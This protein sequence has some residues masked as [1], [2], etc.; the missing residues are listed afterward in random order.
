VAEG[1]NLRIRVYVGKEVR[2]DEQI[3][4]PADEMDRI[5]P[6]LAEKHATALADTPHMVEIEFLDEP[7]PNQRF[8]RF[9]TD[10]TLMLKPTAVEPQDMDKVFRE[11][12]K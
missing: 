7:D 2:F 12:F 10:S 4:A 8:A 6:Q 3:T 11:I 1:I 5:L 9:G